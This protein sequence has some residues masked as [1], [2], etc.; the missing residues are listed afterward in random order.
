VE[1][2]GERVAELL[3]THS[4]QLD[5]KGRLSLPAKFREA[6]GEGVWMTI[7]QD[8]CLYCFPRGEW[9]QRS[10]EVKASSLS[11][12]DGRAFGRLFFGSSAEGELDSQ[13]RVTVP[14]RLREAAGIRKDVIVVGVMDRMEIWD[15]ET[16]TRYLAAYEGAYQAG[17]LAPGRRS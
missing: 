2:R 12:P 4:Y 11:D 10:A 14:Q 8:R 1:E 16:H 13:G 17:T 5:P 9:Q 7:G 15:R 3:G 6:F